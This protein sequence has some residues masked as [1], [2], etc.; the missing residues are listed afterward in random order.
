MKGRGI[1]W[2]REAITKPASFRITTA[3][4]EQFSL[5]KIATSKLILYQDVSGGQHDVTEL[6]EV[7]CIVNSSSCSFA[8]CRI[9]SSVLVCLPRQRLFRRLHRAQ[10][11]IE[12]KVESLLSASKL[13]K[14]G[15]CLKLLECYGSRVG[16]GSTVLQVL[17]KGREHVSQLLGEF[18]KFPIFRLWLP[19]ALG[20][21][22]LKAKNSYALA[23]PDF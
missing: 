3:T 13:T 2:D 17:D 16:L 20:D 10:I 6:T 15:L 12:N 18:D 23:K 11:T 8:R 5:S 4:P 1:C 9:F 14:H 7:W 19:V 21:L 22:P